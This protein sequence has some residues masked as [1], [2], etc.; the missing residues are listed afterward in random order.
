MIR[1]TILP[2]P[3]EH[4]EPLA[5]QRAHGGLVCFALLALLLGIDLRPEGMPERCSGPLHAGVAEA[6]RALEAPVDAAFLATTFCHRGNAGAL[7]EFGGGRLARLSEKG[8]MT[9]S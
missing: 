2:T 8:P 5:R 1:G 9:L 3:K 6:C 4:T 7:L